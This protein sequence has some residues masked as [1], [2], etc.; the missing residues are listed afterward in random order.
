MVD[1]WAS[2]GHDAIDSRLGTER[3]A[4]ASTDGGAGETGSWPHFSSL[5][6]IS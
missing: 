1:G 2:A 3:I 4:H 5:L 6:L